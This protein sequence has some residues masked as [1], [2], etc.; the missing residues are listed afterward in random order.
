MF[1]R[2]CWA[3]LAK[4]RKLL[5]A[6]S[7][8]M[9]KRDLKKLALLGL[10]SGMIL[11]NQSDLEASSS[12]GL[13]DQDFLN[14]LTQEEL[15]LYQGLDIEGQALARLIAS[16]SCGSGN[17][18]RSSARRGSG[19]RTHNSCSGNSGCS[20]SGG[21]GNKGSSSGGNHSCSGSGSC[22]GN[23][24]KSNADHGS[25]DDH[26]GH[27]HSS[28]K[29]K[30]GGH[31]ALRNSGHSCGGGGG[32]GGSGGSNGHSGH[33][34][35]SNGHNDHSGHNHGGGNAGVNSGNGHNN[36]GHSCSGQGGCGG[37]N[38][39]SGKSGCSGNNGCGGSGHSRASQHIDQTLLLSLSGHQ[40]RALFQSLS[41]EGK[42]LALQLAN[43]ECSGKNGCQ[44]LNSCRNDAEGNSC[45]GQCSCRGHAAAPFK[46]K[47]LA[48]RVAAMHD[49]RRSTV[50]G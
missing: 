33:N 4:L 19:F 43:Q 5:N 47:S 32:C 42:D 37:Q 26:S 44:G 30:R 8:F 48:I 7:A 14:S 11:A 28:L 13:A 31:V 18:S 17:C 50:R 10:A 40:E 35:G 3:A 15:S 49:K 27:G 41:V 9:K 22:G 21:C 34:H 2:R 36:N 1:I 16:P 25:H 39:P 29:S 6:R 24:G 12:E 46:S 20:G 38:T 45:A 23:S